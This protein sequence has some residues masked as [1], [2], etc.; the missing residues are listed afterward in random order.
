MTAATLCRSDT[1]IG[2][3]PDRW[4]LLNQ[5]LFG[6]IVKYLAVCLFEMKLQKTIIQ[7][8]FTCYHKML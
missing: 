4:T 8:K 7:K 2:G 5:W 3:Y 6:K 1:G